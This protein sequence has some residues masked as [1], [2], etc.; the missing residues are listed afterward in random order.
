MAMRQQQAESREERRRLRRDAT[1]QRQLD[2]ANARK[3]L[4]ED[5]VAKQQAE[6]AFRE[7][8]VQS[9]LDRLISTITREDQQ[10]QADVAHAMENQ[11]RALQKGLVE[12]QMIAAKTSYE[13][14]EAQRLA[15]WA[16]H[17]QQKAAAEAEIKRQMKLQL[18][19]EQLEA[20]EAHIQAL[21]EE[22]RQAAIMEV[23]RHT[24]MER[25]REKQRLARVK[26]LKQ[27][28]VDGDTTDNGSQKR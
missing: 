8:V 28:D 19:K 21:R 26:K 22:R 25:D 11:K 5:R 1:T 27:G 4:R 14:R 18:M 12:A 7:K 17:A 24:E 23:R 9:V 3:V 15:R 6:A 20:E 10:R 16:A 2:T 13:E